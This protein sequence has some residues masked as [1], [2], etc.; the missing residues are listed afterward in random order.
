L[1]NGASRSWEFGYH[2]E[3]LKIAS[4]CAW[5]T[6]VPSISGPWED[7]KWTGE[8]GRVDDLIRKYTDLW[9]L[10]GETTVAYL[11]GHPD[12]IE[13]GKGILKRR[14]F[15]KEALKE[16]VYWIPAKKSA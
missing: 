4:E 10:S 14:G 3:V 9:G 15:P 1:L 12:M 16:E 8:V 13:H 5:L 7:E 11:C 6:Y 2:E